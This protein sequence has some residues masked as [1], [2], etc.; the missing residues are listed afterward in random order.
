M[1]HA[2]VLAAALS[3]AATS[4][5]K[6]TF[7]AIQK[8]FGT[9]DGA[10]YHGDPTDRRLMQADV[11]TCAKGIAQLGALRATT[12][13]QGPEKLFITG[14]I[15]D[16]AATLSYI[17]L[18]DYVTAMREVKLANLYFRIASELP[19]ES[20]GYRDAARANI[21]LTRIQL[22]TLRTES[23]AAARATAGRRVVTAYHKL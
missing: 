12:A 9:M 17:G 14:R 7:N 4:R 5:A 15:L 8:C 19:N 6:P 21:A 20:A 13:T 16:R 3:S 11:D 18:G 22:Q 1:L 2:A 23:V 10:V